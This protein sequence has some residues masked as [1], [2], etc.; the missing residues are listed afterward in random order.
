MDPL[1]KQTLFLGDYIARYIPPSSST[2]NSSATFFQHGHIYMDR[3]SQAKFCSRSLYDMCRYFV[4]QISPQVGFTIDPDEFLGAFR[5]RD[6]ANQ[7]QR[8]PHWDDTLPT[9]VDKQSVW[10]IA[11]RDRRRS[12]LGVWNEHN[13]HTAGL[14]PSRF[15]RESE[16]RAAVNSRNLGESHFHPS[17]G[18][19]SSSGFCQ[20]TS[21]GHNRQRFGIRTS[22]WVTSNRAPVQ[23]TE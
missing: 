12:A 16:L 13:L 10:G 11:A 22:P 4:N 3:L 15:M 14:I 19:I 9:E 6:E 17:L 5:Y 21:P 18:L 8:A 1:A 7:I 23:G 2:G 20:T